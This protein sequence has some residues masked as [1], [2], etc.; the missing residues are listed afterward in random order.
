MSI[1]GL[2]IVKTSPSNDIVCT[3]ILSVV[4]LKC[5]VGV[6]KQLLDLLLTFWLDIKSAD[7]KNIYFVSVYTL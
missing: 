5:F 7:L 3:V 2:H 6:I 1:K 4:V